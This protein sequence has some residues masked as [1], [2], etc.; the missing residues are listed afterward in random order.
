M[1]LKNNLY[2]IEITDKDTW[3]QH[4]ENFLDANIYQTWNFPKAALSENNFQHLAIF[5]GDELLGLALVRLK[6][7]PLPYSGIAY[8]F[9]GPI[10]QIKNRENSLEKLRTIFSALY[11]Q[12]TLK[13]KFFLRIRPF[14]FIG[15][16]EPKFNFDNL[17][18][19]KNSTINP[20]QSLKLSLSPSLEEIES[21]FR[22]TWRQ[23]LHK[24]LKNNINIQSGMD[25]KLFMTF[26]QTYHQ[27]HDRKKFNEYVNVDRLKYLQDNLEERF[28]FKIF[29]AYYDSIPAASLI[30]SA[31]G[32]S[33][34]AISGG[35]NEFGLKSKASYLLQ[36]E[37]I[38][39]LKSI[40]CD[41][42]DLGGINKLKNP[43]G[44]TWKSGISKFEIEEAGIFDACNV[45]FLRAL[46]SFLDKYKLKQKSK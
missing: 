23:E 35:S 29:I 13:R 42:Y 28:K 5:N 41:Y 11:E 20:Y 22:R 16:N 15:E 44:Y 30:L 24:S 1:Y 36:W 12:Y 45:R 40:N 19:I 2:I 34:I 43:G 21:S 6:F 39:W 38:K 37:A 46:V 7:F 33:G 17:N 31:I 25:D 18:F 9:R 14:L 8:I 4:F 32:N 10:W 27:M 3:N 26:L